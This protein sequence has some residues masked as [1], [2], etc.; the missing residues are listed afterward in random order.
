MDSSHLSGKH[1]VTYEELYILK[2][3]G[4]WEKIAEHKNI[5]DKD[6]TIY[7]KD[8]VVEE[9]IEI[10]TL[11]R[12][13][14][15]KKEIEAGKNTK[16]VDIVDMKNLK[17]DS[18]YRVKGYQ[19]IK[20]DKKE[21][22][23]GNEKIE[24][25]REFVAKDKNQKEEVVF[26]F[27][28]TNLSGKTLVT[29]EE[30]YEEVDGEWKKVAEHKDIDDKDQ[31]VLIKEKQEPKETQKET[32]KKSD[33]KKPEKIN[34]GTLPKTGDT[35]NIGLYIGVALLSSAGVIG[36]IIYRKKRK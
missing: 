23:I 31:S 29:F 8:K 4:E 27:D 25:T 19:M 9:K 11:A 6:Q 32:Y 18:K 7:V 12:G 16:I 22:V 13:E 20:E 36:S 1:L 15:G 5:E 2:E 35:S 24:V 14:N 17:K 30:L 3:S 10:K 26:I 28:S 33:D 21:L 34:K